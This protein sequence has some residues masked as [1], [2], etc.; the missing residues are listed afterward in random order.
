M[1]Y[2]DSLEPGPGE[3]GGP[4]QKFRDPQTGEIRT[5][6]LLQAYLDL[7]KRMHRMIEVPGEASSDEQLGAYRRA[8]GIPDSPDGYQIEQRHEML[9]SD[10]AVN[11]RLHDAGFTPRQAQ[12][13]YDLGHDCVLPMLS[14]MQQE[15]ESQRGL[16]RLRDHFGGDSRWSDTARQVSSWGKANLPPEV[17]GA[18]ANSAEG[19]IAMRT[20][21]ASG[22]P[23]MGRQPGPREDAADEGELKKMMQDPRY[24]KKRDPV[25]IEKVSAGFRKLYGEA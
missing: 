9:A 12:L 21:M 11:Q 16:E 15:F 14:G 20:M 24:W 5:D 23:G 6:A 18:L 22:E 17:Y 2:E 4:P 10:P 13:V 1:Y 25:F 19:V 3:T 7:E 8:M